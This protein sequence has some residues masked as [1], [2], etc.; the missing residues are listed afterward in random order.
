MS[1]LPENLPTLNTAPSTPEVSHDRHSRLAFP[2]PSGRIPFI[3]PLEYP[4][5]NLSEPSAIVTTVPPLESSP[6]KTD[7]PRIQQTNLV[8]MPLCHY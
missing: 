7:T 5:T 2:S 6:Q 4:C 1:L 8:G 3:P